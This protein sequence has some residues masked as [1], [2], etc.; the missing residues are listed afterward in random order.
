MC[1]CAAWHSRRE[2]DAE[3]GHVER[4]L[5]LGRLI[6]EA[7]KTESRRIPMRNLLGW[8]RLGRL[9]IYQL[10][11]LHYNNLTYL[12]QTILGNLSYSKVILEPA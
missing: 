8:L 4:A 6:W 10:I 7:R 11:K 1:A 3:R 12:E 9:K 5:G 2:P